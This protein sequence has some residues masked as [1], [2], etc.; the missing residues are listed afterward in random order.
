[1]RNPAPKPSAA[2]PPNAVRFVIDPDSNATVVEIHWRWGEGPGDHET[3][4]IEEKQESDALRALVL[5]MLAAKLWEDQPT[6]LAALGTM[7]E[8]KKKNT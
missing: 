6:I 3:H 7:T 8:E 2:L 4:P 1:M 5:G